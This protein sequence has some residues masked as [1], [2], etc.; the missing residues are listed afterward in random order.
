MLSL[1]MIWTKEFNFGIGL[2]GNE[3]KMTKIF[4][5]MRQSLKS[6]VVLIDIIVFTGT[7]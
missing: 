7:F 6:M 1:R 4:G 3:M 2:L 5:L